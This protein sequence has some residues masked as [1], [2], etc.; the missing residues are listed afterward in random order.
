VVS[1][2]AGDANLCLVSASV[3]QAI[4]RE[5]LAVLL[6]CCEISVSVSF[7]MSLD[8]IFR[9]EVLGAASD[10]DLI[11]WLVYAHVVYVHVCWEC[12]L[13]EVDR[14]EA[15][16]HS[17]IGDDVHGLLR[18]WP[19]ACPADRIRSDSLGSQSPRC[20]AA[21]NPGDISIVSWSILETIYL[22]ASLGSVE[23]IRARVIS[24]N[25]HASRLLEY[26]TNKGVRFSDFRFVDDEAR[27]VL[28]DDI[29]RVVGRPLSG[30]RDFS[31]KRRRVYG[32]FEYVDLGRASSGVGA[33]R[34][35]WTR[36]I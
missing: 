31:S 21:G 19:L 22:E 3:N 6:P 30:L 15:G 16:R 34:V 12:K 29:F 4:L 35:L 9:G 17:E 7:N 13:V 26:A 10:V 11:G 28:D 18:Y 5:R 24:L 27:R 25:K 23:F 2:I 8:V 36:V 1:A 20:L 32:S 14:A 33:V